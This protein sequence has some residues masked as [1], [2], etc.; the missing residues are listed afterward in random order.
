M[1]I[2]SRQVISV[3]D[4]I[5]KNEYGL[6][7]TQLSFAQAEQAV[8]RAIYLYNFQR[9]HFSCELK[10]PQYRHAE[11][12]NRRKQNNQFQESNSKH[13]TISGIISTENKQNQE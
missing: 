9:P 3:Q 13:Q 11:G 7:Q 1:I 4:S 2:M 6:N 5:L 8:Q 10:T 12:K